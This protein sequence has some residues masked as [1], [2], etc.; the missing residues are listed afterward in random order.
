MEKGYYKPEI[1]E[2]CEGIEYEYLA[3]STRLALLDTSAGGNKLEYLTPKHDIWNKAVFNCKREYGFFNQFD[4][5]T[6]LENGNIRVKLLNSADIEAEWFNPH[7]DGYLKIREGRYICRLWHFCDTGLVVIKCGAD[8]IFRGTIK[9]KTEFKKL[10]KQ[11]G[12]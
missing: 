9:N 12:I 3:C 10:L 4:F 6:Y 7:L 5:N 1:E 11:L 8:T 2:F